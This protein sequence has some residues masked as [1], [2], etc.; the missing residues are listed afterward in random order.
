MCRSPVRLD[1]PTLAFHPPFHRQVSSTKLLESFTFFCLT[2]RVSVI[3]F[4]FV[5]VG[6]QIS[7]A[8]CVSRVAV[9]F[10]RVRSIAFFNVPRVV[11]SGDP[12]SSSQDQRACYIIID[13]EWLQRDSCTSRIFC[14]KIVTLSLSFKY[15]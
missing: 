13:S 4:V 15:I 1:V 10:E 7:D 11:D 3:C 14:S 5:D 2:F 9:S 8:T 6:K 12:W